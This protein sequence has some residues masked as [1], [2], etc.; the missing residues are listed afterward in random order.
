VLRPGGRVVIGVPV[1]LGPP[2]FAK[3]CFR[4]VRRPEDFDARP[5]TILTAALGRPPQPRPLD[6]IS[7][8][9]AYYPHHAGFDHRRLV[10]LVGERFTVERKAGS[11]FP[12]LP[13][14]LNSELY[15]RARKAG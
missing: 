13:L 7:P 15:I 8:G 11:P 5:A 10:R 2:A 12:A 3:G 9:R 6:E 14:W 4:A 1:E